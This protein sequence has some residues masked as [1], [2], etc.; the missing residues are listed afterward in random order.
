MVTGKRRL[1]NEKHQSVS[2]WLVLRAQTAIYR[3]IALSIHI[4]FQE[5]GDKFNL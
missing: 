5:E 1:R 3:S 2:F 4:L